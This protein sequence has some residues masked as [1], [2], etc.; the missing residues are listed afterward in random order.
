MSLV[1]AF[2]CTTSAAWHG[3]N[4]YYFICKSTPFV[5]TYRLTDE[6]TEA[7]ASDVISWYGGLHAVIS[8]YSLIS[9]FRVVSQ[10]RVDIQ[11]PLLLG[12]VAASQGALVKPEDRWRPELQWVSIV[13]TGLAVLHGMLALYLYRKTSKGVVTGVID[14]IQNFI[15]K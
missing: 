5:S 4:A 2:L 13:S 14:S 11:V 3:I 12:A 8:A 10:K 1:A 9:V 7:L 6:R 15:N